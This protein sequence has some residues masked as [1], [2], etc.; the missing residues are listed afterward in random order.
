MKIAI[1]YSLPSRRMMATKYGETDEDSA[2]I[3]AKVKLG[4]ES[5]GME[6]ATYVIGEDKIEEIETIKA[7]CIFNLIEWCGLDIELSQRAF[8]CLR[9]LQIPVTGSSEELFVLTGDKTRVKQELQKMGY[10]TPQGQVFESGEE[11]VIP[12]EYPVIVKPSL[13]HCSTGLTYDSIAQSEG[14]LRTIVKRQIRAFNQSA[15]AEEFVVGREL[16]V[17]LLQEKD[18]VR[19]LPIEEVV[20][21]SDNPLSFQ[22]YQSKWEVDH[23]DYQTST[24][25]VAKLSKDEKSKVEDVCIKIFRELGFSG[26]ARFDLRLKDGIPYVLETNANP[27]VYDGDGSLSDP[28]EEVIPGIKFNDYLAT[29]VETAIYQFGLH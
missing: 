10:P 17:Y 8:E 13:E 19:V 29:I 28:N 2:V 26:Y 7:D 16:L 18:K 20:F 5:K 6:T 3:A 21:S 24:V 27:S 23:P 1:V 22:T 14:E 11:V 9:K 12:L 15:L 25:V 4:L